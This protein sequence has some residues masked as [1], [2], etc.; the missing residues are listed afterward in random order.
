MIAGD[1]TLDF[2]ALQKNAVR[3]TALLKSMSNEWRLL[4]MCRLAEG[5]LSVGELGRL[6]G[7]SQSALSQHLAILR[8]ERLVKT[9]RVAQS[10]FYSLDSYEAQR[11]ME[12]L[13]DLY[14]RDG[15]VDE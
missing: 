13:Y 9:R 6:I 2:A 12:T 14:C 1:H 15:A 8:R 11:I 10:V 7:M 4:I 3:A 5:E